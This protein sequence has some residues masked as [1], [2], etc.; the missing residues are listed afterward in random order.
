MASS[1]I[2]YP[3][4]EMWDQIFSEVTYYPGEFDAEEWAGGDE[5][6]LTRRDITSNNSTNR[7][8][9]FNRTAG[10]NER[11]FRFQLKTRRFLVLVCR[12]WYGLAIRH[13]YTSILVKGDSIS[14][15]TSAVI[16][17]ESL[18]P[19][20]KRLEAQNHRD[21][22]SHLTNLISKCPNLII[23]YELSN[24]D[25]F[26]TSWWRFIED[27]PAIPSKL[28]HAGGDLVA[29]RSTNFA[30]K[31]YHFSSLVAL[32]LPEIFVPVNVD[33]TSHAPLILPKLR[34]LDFGIVQN[35]SKSRTISF[36]STWEMPELIAVWV[37]VGI[38]RFLPMTE[39]W[40]KH[41]KS[42][43]TI[44]INN[45]NLN[46]LVFR[47]GTVSLGIE[48][49]DQTLS[50]I[51]PRLRQLIVLHNSLGYYARL[52]LPSK[53]LE[54]YEVPFHHTTPR[55]ERR[56]FVLDQITTSNMN[57]L[58]D[59]KAPN[60]RIFRISDCPNED[61]ND[62]PRKELYDEFVRSRVEA[63]K[64]KFEARGVTLELRERD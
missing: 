11:D 1:Q 35:V 3:P 32:R 10:G 53:S 47:S 41:G 31:I 17:N 6:D 49:I 57:H 42:L 12:Q 62:V 60:L 55:S 13:L 9:L 61:D 29:M 23:Y 28:R 19:L 34:I 5:L 64:V 18:G 58:P 46:M 59:G 26:K 4:P 8:I 48:S 56:A 27:T 63:M 15:V 45:L 30:T 16:S 25:R 44:K 52:F 51:F 36:I 43:T 39:F 40:R 2:K 20:V 50:E 24:E 37:P 22:T 38:E 21:Y 33:S 54:I 14:K 7:F